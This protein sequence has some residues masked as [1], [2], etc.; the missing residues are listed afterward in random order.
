MI[1]QN[2]QSAFSRRSCGT[3]CICMPSSNIIKCTPTRRRPEQLPSSAPE[4]RALQWKMNCMRKKSFHILLLCFSSRSSWPPFPKWRVQHT[5]ITTNSTLSCLRTSVRLSRSYIGSSFEIVASPNSKWL[6]SPASAHVLTSKNV[7]TYVTYSYSQQ[8][9]ET[10]MKSEQKCYFASHYYCV[11]SSPAPLM[12]AAL[13][14]FRM[15]RRLQK[16]TTLQ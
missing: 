3:M 11:S 16:I 7:S 13:L 12:P 14:L 15:F 4:A 10:M 8:I 9:K 1:V 6:D 5:F 2:E